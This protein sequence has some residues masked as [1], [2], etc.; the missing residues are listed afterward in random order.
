MKLAFG[1]GGT[2]WQERIDFARMRKERLAKGQSM[3][4]KYGIPAALLTRADNIRYM[5]GIRSA[6]EFA[7]Q[8]R[9]ALIFVEHEP[10]MYELGDCLEHTRIHCTW[11]KPENWRYSVCS[12]GGCCGA[13]ATRDSATQW[14]EGIFK[15]L[16][17]KGLHREK[18]GIDSIDEASRQA[19][20]KLGID[21]VGVMPAMREARRV[22][23]REEILCM[24]MGVAI[25][26]VGYANICE[27]LRPGRRECDVGGLA[28]HAMLQVG[29]EFSKAG[30]RSGPNTFE[31]YH[32]GNQDR[33]IQFG[34]LSYVNLCSTTYMGYRIC[35]Y[36][37]FIAG[38]RPNQKEKEW[39]SK[40]HDRLYGVIDEIKPGA[41]TADAAKHFLPASHWGYEADERLL[42][43]EVGHGIGMT[44]DEPIISRIWSFDHPQVFEPG[45]VIAVEGREGEPGYGGVR[46]EEMVVVTETGHEVITTWPSEEIMPVGLL[47]G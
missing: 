25:G 28:M 33:V 41:T 10:I 22:K 17:A 7:P 8:L 47:M 15:D 34:D 5:T 1:A 12:L 26:E 43:S 2:D 40:L 11:I 35:V 46:F 30:V 24:R 42:V 21:V 4:K 20:A 32:I 29:A 31:V 6:G 14:A 18:L 9:Y 19:L 36:R 37:S 13:E 3:M 39:Y 38:R 27:H 45:M 16:K 44:Y 23:T